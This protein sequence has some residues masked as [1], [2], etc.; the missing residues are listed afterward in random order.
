MREI[1]KKRES[2]AGPFENWLQKAFNAIPKG[3]VKQKLEA[4]CDACGCSV[5]SFYRWKGSGRVPN[6]AQR[7]RI[8]EILNINLKKTT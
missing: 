2:Q 7:D 8:C 5:P 1:V 4:I 6:K 3:E